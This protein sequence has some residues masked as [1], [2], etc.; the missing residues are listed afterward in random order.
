M[1]AC[2]VATRVPRATE[3][4]QVLI[5]QVR[6]VV[7][8]DAVV[9]KSLGVLAE[10]ELIEPLRDIFG[11]PAAPMP[12][13]WLARVYDLGGDRIHRPRMSEMSAW[14]QPPALSPADRRVRY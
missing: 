10:P 2:R 8:L 13:R 9:S 11:H 14:G 12:F 6:K 1:A 4:L 7:Q 3:L 5:R